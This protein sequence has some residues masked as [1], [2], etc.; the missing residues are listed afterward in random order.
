MTI[1]QEYV[2]M[3]EKLQVEK[4]KRE[5]LLHE[6]RYESFCVTSYILLNNIVINVF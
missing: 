4:V 2:S 5:I 1:L 3:E 6:V